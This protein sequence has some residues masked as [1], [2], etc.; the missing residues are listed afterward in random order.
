[1]ANE[2]R[3][4]KPRTYQE[5]ALDHLKNLDGISDA[6]EA[7]HLQLYAGYVKQ[8]RTLSEQLHEMIGRGK[9]PARARLSPS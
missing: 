7:E 6:Q 5:Q 2:A 4:F 8:V 3:P 9:P 1:M